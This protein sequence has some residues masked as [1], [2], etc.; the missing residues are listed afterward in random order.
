MKH[1]GFAAIISLVALSLTSAGTVCAGVVMAE[2]STARGPDGQ[3]NSQVKTIYVQGNKQKVEKQDVA[4]ITDLD[5]SIVYIIDM[6]HRSYAEVPL[7]SLS[8]SLPGNRPAESIKLDRTG[9][10]RVIANNPCNEYRASKG[11]KL[12][13]IT[14]SA[15]VSTSAPGA[16]EVSEFERKMTARLSGHDS[17]ERSTPLAAA[18]L[19][20]EKKSVVS[21]RMPDPSLHRGY[22]TA[23]LSDETQ[24]NQIHLKSLPAETF[25]PPKGFSELRNGPHNGVPTASPYAA[26]NA[27]EV[28]APRPTAATQ[29][30]NL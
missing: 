25:K 15:C 9:K 22:R 4:S 17:P 16:K 6:Q 18:A 12:E 23:S 11:D 24:V 10:I 27:L 28:I 8:P 20:L 30:S 13:H 3:T 19:M 7:R 5:K 14:I 29:A 2:T 26:G 1:L 21:F